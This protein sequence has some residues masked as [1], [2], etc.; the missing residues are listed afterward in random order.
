MNKAII[1]A[2][3][4]GAAFA[5][6]AESAVSVWGFGDYGINSGYQLY[7]SLLNSEPTMSGYQEVNVNATVDDLDLGSIGF[8]IWSNTDLTD[9]RRGLYG[10]A[11]NEY[12]PNIHYTRTFWFDD[13]HTWGLDYRTEVVWYIYPHHR[14]HHAGNPAAG[15]GHYQSCVST[16]TTMDWNHAFELKNPYVTPYFK[17]VHEYHENKA[18]LFLGGLQKRVGLDEIA[19]GPALRPRADLV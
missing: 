11:F 9:K 7:G 19:E 1:A 12:D 13:D 16:M 6:Q 10:K 14:G 15:R 8:G 2:L 5:A 18:N 3:A 4:A 17:W